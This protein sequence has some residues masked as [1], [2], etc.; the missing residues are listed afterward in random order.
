MAKLT[1]DQVKEINAIIAEIEKVIKPDSEIGARDRS[2]LPGLLAA[3]KETKKP[4]F[5]NCRREHSNDIV[6]HFIREKS[7]KKNKFHMNAQ[8]S[9]YIL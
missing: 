5:F 4:K 2:V 6:N 8:T 9:V 1:Q 7:L 3:S